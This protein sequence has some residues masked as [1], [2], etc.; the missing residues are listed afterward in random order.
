MSVLFDEGYQ[1]VQLALVLV[2]DRSALG[3][4]L[5]E[6]QGGEATDGDT[7]VLDLVGSGIHLGDDN[8]VLVVTVLLGQLFPGRSYTKGKEQ[9]LTSSHNRGQPISTLTQLLAVTAPR[10]IELNEDIL[11]VVDD[12]VVERLALDDDNVALSV[13]SLDL[14]GLQVRLD[15]TL[16]ER[17]N[18]GVDLLSRVGRTVEAELQD[19]RLR[20][21]VSNNHG[22]QAGISDFEVS[23]DL[24]LRGRH[25]D[26]QKLALMLLSNLTVSSQS[27]LVMVSVTVG[28]EQHVLGDRVGEDGLGGLRRELEHPRSGLG[29]HELGDGIG[30]SVSGDGQ[31]VAQVI[32]GLQDDDGVVSSSQLALDGSI[33]RQGVHMK[34]VGLGS[35]DEGLG[36]GGVQ[37][38]E[39]TNGEDVVGLLQLL[40]ISLGGQSVED[41]ASLLLQ[42][43]DD[44]LL[45]TAA[46]VVRG[47]AILE[48]LQGGE[49]TDLELL[50]HVVVSGGINLG[51]LH[52]GISQ[53]LGSLGVFRGQRLAV[54]TPIVKMMN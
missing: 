18:E 11:V 49:A 24:A 17:M 52:R 32:E 22:R 7:R 39:D 36:L 9:S 1:A 47:L 29:S 46:V 50:R 31:L 3:A 4:S 54:T 28:E 37:R 14:L 35:S 5:E 13:S 15:V 45:G 16:L 8:L 34:L 48:E 40:K 33:S 26:E 51:Q 41:R 6:V 38:S 25:V 43:A 20:S 23:Q 10:S 19:T 42:P 53:S 21:Q 27:G 44:L 12:Q 30:L 2:L